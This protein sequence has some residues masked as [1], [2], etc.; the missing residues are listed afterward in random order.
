M[1]F[2]HPATTL[3][4]TE[5]ARLQQLML[6]MIGSR[7]VLAAILRRKLASSISAPFS[8]L[9][10]DRAVSGKL[11][12]F[13]IDDK[14][15]EERILTWQPLKADDGKS[16]SLLSPRGLALIGLTPGASLFYRAEGDRTEFL[17]VESVSNGE[18]SRHDAQV[19]VAVP[20][21]R[22]PVIAANLRPAPADVGAAN[23]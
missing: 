21:D 9:A 8:T 13:S 15:V 2:A 18:A 1:R 3:S 6:T 23:V 5:Y 14:I 22:A 17:R 11:V 19:A 10:P 12:R 20:R 4:S 16:L 7:T